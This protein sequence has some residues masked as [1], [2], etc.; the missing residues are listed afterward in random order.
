MERNSNS[1]GKACII[2]VFLFF[3]LCPGISLAETN[4]I[5]PFF[6]SSEESSP[7]WSS[8]SIYNNSNS[9]G[10]FELTINEQDGDVALFQGS[11]PAKGSFVS[12]ISQILPSTT[13][14]STGSGILGD[15]A[16]FIEVNCNFEGNGNGIIS[17]PANGE[18]YGVSTTSPKKDFVFPY[19]PPFSNNLTYNFAISIFNSSNSAGTATLLLHEAD[20]DS[21]IISLNIEEKGLYVSLLS[22]LMEAEEVT[23]V[24]GSGEFG[25]AIGFIEVSSD[26]AGGGFS[27][28]SGNNNSGE[29]MS[30][31]TV[32][33]RLEGD[34]N[35]NGTIDLADS[36]FILQLLTGM[37]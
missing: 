25:D 5:F 22:V 27:W 32:P 13:L 33:N 17:N 10:N 1:Q 24:S 37:R 19:F 29:G 2:L 16:N 3:V 14:V 28:L 35:G 34:F 23:R 31:H 7:F 36:I 11:I 4:F 21:A 30:I 26:F 9:L 6:P 18:S 20:G 12:L 8:L 15:S